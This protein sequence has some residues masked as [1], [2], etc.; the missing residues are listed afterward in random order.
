[1]PRRRLASPIAL[2]MGMTLVA[3]SYAAVPAG[4]GAASPGAGASDVEDI[5]IGR[6][7]RESRQPPTD[8]C[9]PERTGFGRAS[10]EDTYTFR[11]VEA[12]GSDGLVVNANVAVIGTLRACFG[13]LPE[14][15]S[16]F[17]AE[18]KLGDVPFT[19]RGECRTTR[20]DHPE[21]GMSAQ[22]CFMELS[23]LPPAYVGGQLTTNTIGTR[24]ALG[25]RTDP[26]GYTQP[27]IATIRLWKRR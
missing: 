22:R 17:Y 14:T 19:G 5:Y 26:P 18:G 1:M 21:A 25:D 12:R 8:F 4:Q 3:E 7:W 20:R 15:G 24:N 11:S 6:S 9:A 16:F 2:V 27:S 10:V 13:P 23:G